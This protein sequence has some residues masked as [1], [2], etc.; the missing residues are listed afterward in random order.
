MSKWTYLSMVADGDSLEI[1]GIN[2]WGFKWN[3]LPLDP[4]EIPHPSYPNQK[5]K[6]RIYSIEAKGKTVQFAA[7]ELSNCAWCFYVQ[8]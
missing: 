2:V 5:H 8:A 1:D 4:I 7:A 3:S 6:L